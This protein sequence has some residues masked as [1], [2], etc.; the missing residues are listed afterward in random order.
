MLARVFIDFT[1]PPDL[2]LAKRA[3]EGGIVGSNPTSGAI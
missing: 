1:A 2:L 3:C